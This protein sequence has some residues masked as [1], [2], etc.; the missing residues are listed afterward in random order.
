MLESVL[1]LRG[2]RGGRRLCEC[3]CEEHLTQRTEQCCNALIGQKESKTGK[4]LL[5]VWAKNFRVHPS[6]PVE[7]AT[8]AQTASGLLESQPDK[9]AVFANIREDVSGLFPV[10]FHE[11]GQLNTTKGK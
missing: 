6:S 9:K 10:A 5:A 1:G 3:C 2:A 8:N 4:H 11:V 7:L